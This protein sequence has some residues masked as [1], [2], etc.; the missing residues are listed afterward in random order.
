MKRSFLEFVV[1]AL[2]AIA[3]VEITALG[4]VEA[5]DGFGRGDLIPFSIWITPFGLAVGAAVLAG[6]RYLTKAGIAGIIS[7]GLIT[8]AAIG[9]LWTLAL[10][11]MMGPW[12]GTFSFPVLAILVVGGALSTAVGCGLWR[13]LKWGAD[14]R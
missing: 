12:F 3:T 8:G 13:K 7:Y 4:Y 6:Q 2:L 5:H 10:L 14:R 11:W 9:L 1:S